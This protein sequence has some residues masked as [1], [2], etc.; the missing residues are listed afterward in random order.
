[1]RKLG[2]LLVLAFAVAFAAPAAAGVWVGPAASYSWT[3]ELDF[4]EHNILPALAVGLDAGPLELLA[5]H[6]V[7]ITQSPNEWFKAGKYEVNAVLKY[8]F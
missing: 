3:N 8:R 7:D 5:K 1:V 4:N 6:P 2:L